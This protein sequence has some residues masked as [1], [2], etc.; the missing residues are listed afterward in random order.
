MKK[1]NTNIVI[2][3]SDTDLA[4]SYDSKSTIRC[5]T[6][7]GGNLITWKSKKQNTVARSSTKLKY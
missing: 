2:G 1:N 4:G 5:V 6:F 3:Y 7:I